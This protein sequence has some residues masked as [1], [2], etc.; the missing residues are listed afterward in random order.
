[1]AAFG[2]KVPDLSGEVLKAELL[3]VVLSR[4]L[5]MFSSRRRRD[6][7]AA[8]AESGVSLRAYALDRG[9]CKSSR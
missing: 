6:P 2:W 1:M 4:Y 9:I 3:L 7:S 5:E 8:E